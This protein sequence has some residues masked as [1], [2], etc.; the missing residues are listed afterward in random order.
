MASLHDARAVDP[1]NDNHRVTVESSISPSVRRAALFPHDDLPDPP[2]DHPQKLIRRPGYMI[3]LFPGATFGTVA[4]TAIEP[5][6][7]ELAVDD[8]RAVLIEHGMRRSAWLI[9]DA[10]SPSDL[11]TRLERLGMTPSDEPP[12]EPH[13][14]AL[15]L[16]SPPKPVPTD[17]EARLA[18]TLEE[19]VAARR[20][21]ADAFD[22]NDDDRAAFEAMNQVLWELEQRDGKYRTYVALIDGEVIGFAA[23]VFGANAVYLSGAGTRA[24]RRGRG[25]YRALVRARWD[26]AVERGTPA[27]TVGAGMMS[28]PILE[29]LGFERVGR[30][31]CLLDKFDRERTTT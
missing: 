30:I 28:G 6:A 27:L 20:I 11:A 2:P 4:V 29:R 10:A 26:T 8:V 31:D 3:G 14:S 7:L 1:L 15:A 23:V 5:D 17:A 13:M 21:T 16:T 24:D 18:E 9:V 22:F 19:F 25:A 12:F